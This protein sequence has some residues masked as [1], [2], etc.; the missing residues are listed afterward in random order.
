[1]SLNEWYG[2]EATALKVGLEQPIID[3]VK[4]GKE[5]VGLAPKDEIVIRFGREL[6]RQRHVSAETFAKA[7][8]LFGQRGTV[9]MI[10]VMGD[11]S[12]VGL[13]LQA[14]DQQLPGKPALPPLM[15]KK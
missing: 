5:P 6:F 14:V 2:H 15:T 8:E 1:M 7:V 9:E 11:Y 3:I 12:M 10:G 4:L 13:M